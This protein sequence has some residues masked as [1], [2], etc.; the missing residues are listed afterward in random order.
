ML[1]F[2]LIIPD[3][4]SFYLSHCTT[5]HNFLITSHLIRSHHISSHLMTSHHVSSY[6]ITSH[7]FS[8]PPRPSDYTSP[9]HFPLRTCI[10]FT[11]PSFTFP[12]YLSFHPVLKS[13]TGSA[14]RRS[15][16]FRPSGSFCTLASH[17][18]A[19]ELLQLSQLVFSFKI[20]HDNVF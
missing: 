10:D 13:D 14:R 16:T 5:T 19:W 7:C 4:I 3:H 1:Y 6:V 20:V 12:L 17:V 15:S 2:C 11:P 8:C 9:W 18:R